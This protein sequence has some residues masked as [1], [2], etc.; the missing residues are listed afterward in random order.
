MGGD[1][2]GLVSGR[3]IFSCY[4]QEDCGDVA[5]I[6]DWKKYGVS[7]SLFIDGICLVYTY[8]LI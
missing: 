7:E 8:A 2:V 4:A 5:A 6:G 3:E 1:G